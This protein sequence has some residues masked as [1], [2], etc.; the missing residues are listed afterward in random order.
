M[1]VAQSVRTYDGAPAYLF[2]SGIIVT[3]EGWES[4]TP[5]MQRSILDR[6]ERLAS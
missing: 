6:E 5:E 4:I 1:T 2:P 3:V